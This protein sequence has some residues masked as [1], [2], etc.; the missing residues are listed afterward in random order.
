MSVQPPRP[1]RNHAIKPSSTPPTNASSFERG[2]LNLWCKETPAHSWY[3][4]AK[5]GAPKPAVV[6][7]AILTAS[8]YLGSRNQQC[9]HI[10]P[11][12]AVRLTC[13]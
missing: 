10:P 5:K 6:K 3:H 1:Q 2:D 8:Q 7:R 4:A 12:R 9:D 13:S 11:I